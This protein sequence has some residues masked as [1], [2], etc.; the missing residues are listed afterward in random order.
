[1]GSIVPGV[2]AIPRMPVADGSPAT[3]PSV[4][5]GGASKCISMRQCSNIIEAVRFA[6]AMGIPLVAHLTIHWS[7]T[8]IGDDPNGTLFAKV[9]EG[10]HKC[11]NRRGIV[12]AGV[13]ARERQCQRA[14]RR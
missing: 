13:W 5:R 4:R 10:L 6:E 8:D 1:M 9:R 3:E 11:L 7:L 12:F 14:V 2:V